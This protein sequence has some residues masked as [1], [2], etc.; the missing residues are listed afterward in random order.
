MG[1]ALALRVVRTWPGGAG[2]LLLGLGALLALVAPA[3]FPGDPLDIAARPL[4]PPFADPLVPLG[5]DRLGRDIL[6]GLVHGAR[7]SLATALAVA[8]LALLGGGAVGT[9]AGYRGGWTD[10]ALMRVADAGQTGPS[11]VLALAL[12]SV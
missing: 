5:T 7:A 11:F 9:V 8:A 2:V 1:D 4:T 6:A 12:R 3:L 10:E